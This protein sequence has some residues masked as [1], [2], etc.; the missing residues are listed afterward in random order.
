MATRQKIKYHTSSLVMNI[1]ESS[2]SIYLVHMFILT[3]LGIIYK[4]IEINT[5]ISEL[6]FLGTMF[7][8]SIF[9][10]Y[11]TYHVIEKRFTIFFR[12]K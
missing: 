1:G 2:Y 5:E 9:V 6:V 4:R 3:F 10:G 7:I 8:M 11:I 12:N